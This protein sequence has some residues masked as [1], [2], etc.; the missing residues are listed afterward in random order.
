MRMM[1]IAVGALAVVGIVFLLVRA[2]SRPEP[3]VADAGGTSP[4]AAPV[5]GSGA[6]TPPDLSTMTPRERFDRLYDRVMRASESGDQATV[7]RF[8]PMALA[9]YGMLDSVD[10]DARYHAALLRLHSGDAA[11][12][13]LLADTMVATTPDHLFGYLARGMVARWSADSGSLE[14]SY[15]DYLSRYPTETAKTRDDYASHRTMLDRF[16]DDAQAALA[17]KKP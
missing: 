16:R 12:A 17:G 6:G 14:K 5:T 11:G 1:P 9:A 13:K 2:D 15:R 4:V 10:T 7:Q 8:G 3:A